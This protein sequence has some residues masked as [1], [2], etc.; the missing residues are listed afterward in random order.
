VK[1]IAYLAN[2]YPNCI[3]TYVSDEILALRKQGAEVVPCS[4]FRSQKPV[5]PELRLLEAETLYLSQLQIGAVFRALLLC[6][7][8]FA[9]LWMFCKCALSDRG[10]TLPRRAKAVLHTALGAYYAALL[11]PR[12]VDHIH[13]HHGYFAAWVAMVAAR[14]LGIGYSI[15]LHGSDLLVHR[16]FLDIKLRNCECCFT[17]SE[18]NREFILDNYPGVDRSK[19][20]LRRLGVAVPQTTDRAAV[21][22]APRPLFVIL[23]VG[24]LHAVKNYRFLIDATAI[25]K[26][27]GVPIF[28]LIAGEGPERPRLELRIASLGLQRELKL[29]GHVP[30]ADLEAVLAMVD[31]VALTSVSEGIP[32][33]L[34]EAMS[35]GRIVLAPA[36]TGI[37]ELVIHGTT[38]FLYEP[39]SLESFVSRM[40][41]LSRSLDTLSPVRDAARTQVRTLFDREQNLQSFVNTL[42]QRISPRV[43]VCH[44]NP[45]L[46][47]I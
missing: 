43:G 31:V 11:A 36:I 20:L 26:S 30:H 45:V 39:N 6:L 19:I 9:T 42:L 7:A 14:L 38:G 33:S 21:F 18:Y 40:E 24:R 34:M 27:R 28:C 32:V 12:E 17:V 15:T 10:E 29:L 3:E 44:E 22:T 47:Q 16:A 8:Q 41:S 25:L 4:V 23:S 46:Q 13:V 1:K 5:V 35:Y 2:Q 37:P